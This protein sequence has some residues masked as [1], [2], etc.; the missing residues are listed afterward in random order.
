[1]MYYAGS[2]KVVEFSLPI[3][4]SM[5]NLMRSLRA[6]V[7]I[8]IIVYGT[9][10]IWTNESETSITQIVHI[11]KEFCIHFMKTFNSLYK[12]KFHQ[13]LYFLYSI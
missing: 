1:M 9:H 13:N 12:N 10:I 5:Y 2:F 6:V 11:L 3:N 4:L 7:Q 8:I